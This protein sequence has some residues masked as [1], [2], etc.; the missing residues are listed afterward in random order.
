MGI[1]VFRPKYEVEECLK[2]IR[3]CLEMGWTGLGF[4]TVQF[5]DCWKEYTGHPFAY[6]INSA[7]VGLN[8]AVDILRES[9]K[10]L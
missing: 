1:Q 10:A 9:M 8:L 7:T 6:F 3:E 5:E 4:K 2:E